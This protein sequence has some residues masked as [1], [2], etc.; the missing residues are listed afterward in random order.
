M[1]S[2]G[3]RASESLFHLEG[4]TLALDGGKGSS[5][6]AGVVSLVV[7]EEGTVRG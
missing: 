1:H 3:K 7:T 2:I 4:V 5:E 6:R